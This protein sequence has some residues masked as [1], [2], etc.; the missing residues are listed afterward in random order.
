MSS[1]YILRNMTKRDINLGDIRYKI[2]ANQARDL[3]SKTAHLDLDSI[4]TSRKNG[5]IYKYLKAGIIVEVYDINEPKAPLIYV[6]NMPK[7]KFPRHLKTK[8]TVEIGD[9]DEEMK[10]ITIDE[11]EDF[12]RELDSEDGFLE[13]VPLIS[14][15]TDDD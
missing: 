7:I 4:N 2:P 12:L 11:E 3:L 15:K 10:K 5:S 13:S 14:K 6:D 8:L 1:R 9:V